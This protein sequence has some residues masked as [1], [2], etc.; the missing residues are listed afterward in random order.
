M[1]TGSP[2]SLLGRY[3]DVIPEPRLEVVLELGQVKIRAATPVQQS[4]SVVIEV[5]RKVEERA[6]DGLAVDGDVPFGQMPAAG[7]HQKR[8]RVLVQAIL[9]ALG[10]LIPDH[11]P[12]GVANVDLSLDR[13]IPCGRVG[14]LEIGHE[15]LAPELSALMTILRSTGPVIST[16]RSSRS[17]GIGATFQSASRMPRVSSRK[18]GSQ[19]SSSLVC[20]SARRASSSFL[21][22]SKARC[23]LAINAS[24]WGVR[25]SREFGPERRR[26]LHSRIRPR[27]RSLASC[28]PPLDKPYGLTSL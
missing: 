12:Y 19:P 6:A 10:A 7:P 1:P 13:R 22:P 24:A 26:D 5:K 20:T 4:L 14:V 25:I 21:R 9:L 16:R 17:G 27:S 23:S 2:S 18:S 15:H 28:C 8:S 11:A 3:E